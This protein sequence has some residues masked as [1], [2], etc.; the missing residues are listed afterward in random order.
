MVSGLV[1]IYPE[2]CRGSVVEGV[3]PLLTRGSGV[4]QAKSELVSG[5]LPT[6]PR[7]F[8]NKDAVQEK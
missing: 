4:T 7:S 8:I 3:E 2:L 1:P 6:Q 5:R